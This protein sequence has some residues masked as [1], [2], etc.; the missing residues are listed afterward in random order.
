VDDGPPIFGAVSGPM[1]WQTELPITL[2]TTVYDRMSGLDSTSARLLVGE[3]NRSAWLDNPGNPWAEQRLLAVLDDQDGPV[4]DGDF[5]AQFRIAD[6]A[7]TAQLSPEFPVK[8]DRTPPEMAAGATLGSGE[9]ISS[10]HG[11]FAGEVLV[12]IDATDAA[13]GLSAAAYVLDNAP[14]VIYTEPFPLTSEGWH[15]V[16]YWAQDVAGNYRYS[17]YFEAG[18]DYTPPTVWARLSGIDAEQAL[19]SWGGGDLLS[20]VVGFRVEM[21]RNAGDWERLLPD[22]EGMTGETSLSLS[23]IDGE[24]VEIRVLAVDQAGNASEWT[25][26]PLMS[27]AQ[28]FLPTITAGP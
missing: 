13:S 19:A 11:W 17:Q 16:R 3:Q 6:Q 4:A 26:A 9:P 27:T 5:L 7:G 14:F 12:R 1:G 21:R 15:V 10:S 18:I 22:G 2:T 23:L 24:T 8:L 28:I 20:G 25:V